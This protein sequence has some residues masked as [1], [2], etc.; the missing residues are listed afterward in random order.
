MILIAA[1]RK[2]RSIEC[3]QLFFR[4]RA[5]VVLLVV[6][7]EIAHLSDGRQGMVNDDRA[8]PESKKTRL[9]P[10]RIYRGV[11]RVSGFEES[12]SARSRLAL[13]ADIDAAIIVT[14]S[15]AGAAHSQPT[16]PTDRARKL[17]RAQRCDALSSR[18]P[19]AW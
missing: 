15:A 19:R 8:R 9:R 6:G 5:A 14:R 16:S 13:N 2:V 12:N 3:R 11:H 10:Q 1:Q 4:E 17:K 7:D 18:R